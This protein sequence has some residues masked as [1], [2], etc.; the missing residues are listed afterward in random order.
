MT[1]FYLVHYSRRS[2]SVLRLSEFVDRSAASNEKLAVEI[3]LLG[4]EDGDEL[5]IL[6]AN[7]MSDLTRSHSRYFADLTKLKPFGRRVD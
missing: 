4:K 6:E 2:R 5:V 7:D 3:G 1:M